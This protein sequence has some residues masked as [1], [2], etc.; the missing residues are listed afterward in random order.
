[1]DGGFEFK[2]TWVAI[3]SLIEAIGSAVPT[4]GI[5]TILGGISFVVSSISSLGLSGEV[6]IGQLN[7][8]LRGR[9]VFKGGVDVSE[10]IFE[11]LGEKPGG[12]TSL[13]CFLFDLLL[14]ISTF[15]QKDLFLPDMRQLQE[16]IAQVVPLD[17]EKFYLKFVP[18]GTRI[19]E[20]VVPFGVGGSLHLKLFDKFVGADLMIDSQGAYLLAYVD[21]IDLWGIYRLQPSKTIG[22]SAQKIEQEYNAWKL[23]LI[24][25]SKEQSKKIALEASAHLEKGFLLGA[26]FDVRIGDLIGGS[27]R[28]R[29]GLGGLDLQGDFSVT[30][31]ELAQSLGVKDGALKLWLKGSQVNLD[32]P[33]LL[34]QQL[35]PKNIG[36]E[37]GFED[38]LKQ[39][40]IGTITGLM[41]NVEGQLNLAV[42][43]VIQGVLTRAK[44]REL[45]GAEELERSFCAKVATDASFTAACLDARA[46]LAALR[47]KEFVFDRL[48]NA[49]MT[50]FP[51]AL[52]SGILAL[53]SL[54]IGVLQG[55]Y[56]GISGLQTIFS[57]EQ[58][59]WRGTLQDLS[60]G[61][62]P[63]FDVKFKLLGAEIV[64]KQVGLFDFT[65]S[66]R[67]WIEQLAL[68]IAQLIV[69]KI[70]EPFGDS[71][72]RVALSW[73]AR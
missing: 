25:S 24:S 7:D 50:L 32:N 21:P 61:K 31:P 58:V 71:V 60:T 56:L 11:I 69:Q 63:G 35:D 65:K 59:V 73:E 42:N 66:P 51:E 48:D 45:I 13:V 38:T 68:D 12:F 29:L 33:L 34:L 14:Y 39:A 67:A 18:L 40:L 57:I 64:L 20:V 3:A 22:R 49:G 8:P 1:R 72:P 6:E 23:P 54:G 2:T 62:I 53:K 41:Q 27:V 46:K 26:D 43:N 5:G 15:G 36:L 16:K 19:G 17:L 55:G 52:R 9:F 47:A 70:L 44:K 28:A 37:I 30:I 4:L 10:L